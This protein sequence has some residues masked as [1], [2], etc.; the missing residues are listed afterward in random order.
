[1]NELDSWISLVSLSKKTKKMI[2]AIIITTIITSIILLTISVR[3]LLLVLVPGPCL[4]LL[5]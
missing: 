2:T 1:M 4:T 3:L 5:G